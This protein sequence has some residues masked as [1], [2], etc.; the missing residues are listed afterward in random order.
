VSLAA[1]V[2][3]LDGAISA[4]GQIDLYA[5]AASDADLAPL[6]PMLAR[7]A[8]TGSFVLR[9]ARLSPSV[10]SATLT[11]TGRWGLA[12]AP[13][14]HIAAISARLDCVATGVGDVRFTLTLT[15]AEPGWT[16][17][18]T[19]AGLPPTMVARDQAVRPSP[20][21]LTGLRLDSAAFAAASGLGAG[22]TLA[23]SLPPA[24]FWAPWQNLVGPWPLQLAGQVVLPAA[25]DGAPVLDLLAAA[26]A[27]AIPLHAPLLNLAGLALTDV[28]FGITSAPGPDPAQP[29]ADAVT[30]LN[31]TGRLRAGGL[32]ARLACPVLATGRLWHFLAQFEDGPAVTGMDQLGKLF[33][34]PELP[35]PPDFLPIPGF[36]LA[37]VEFYLEPGRQ[38]PDF[39]VAYIGVAIE[40]ARHWSLPAP[41]LT[42]QRAGIS[43]LWGRTP[44]RGEPTGWLAATVY[45]TVAFGADESVRI[46]GQVQIPGWSARADLRTGD[47][48]GISAAFREYFGDAGP[49]TP[50]DMNIV[51]LSIDADPLE[52]SYYASADI[53]FGE[54]PVTRIEQLPDGSVLVAQDDPPERGWQIGLVIT[55]ITLR[56]LALHVRVV[57]GELAGGISGIFLFGD[58][59][60]DPQPAFSLSAEY[61]GPQETHPE[62]WTF[63][64]ELAI[65]A[66]IGLH[67]LARR[68]LGQPEVPD[69][70]PDLR[71]DR[72]YFTF[73][74]GEPA[75]YAFGGT[76][77]LRWDPV[78]FGRTLK[79]SAA[80][81]LD[82]AKPAG[83]Q[84]ASGS[85]EGLFSVN[86]LELTARLAIGVPEPTYQFRVRFGELWFTGTTSWHGT[87][88][89]RHQVIS[90]RLGGVTVGEVLE[91]LVGLVAPTLGYSL[92]PPWDVLN[93]I[94]LSSFVLTLDPQE[95]TA[96]LVYA[97][98]ADLI[99]MR[100][101]TIGIRY[102]RGAD[103]GV[104]LIV[105]GS[106]LGQR[107][108]GDALAWDVISEPPPPVPGQGATY[109]RLRYL[110]LG[111]RVQLTTRPDTV[112]AAI[113][114][115]K[116]ELREVKPGQNPLTGQRV[117]WSPISQW[118]IGL[119]VGFLDTVD[120]GVVFSDPWLYGLSVALH[121]EQAG[122]LAGLKFE[123]LYK[124]ISDTTG[125]FRIELT[126]PEAYRTFEFGEV[127]VTLGVAVIEIYTNGNFKIDLGFPHDRSFERSFAVQVFPFI[128]RGGIYLG[129]LDGTTSRR[130][131]VVTNGAFAPVIELGVG[132]TVGVG[133]EIHLGPLAGGIYVE[134]EVI[135]E[136]VLGWFHPA[137]G[138]RAAT[139]YW[140]QGVAAIHGKLYG[141]V[142]FGV[143][144]VLVTL[145]AYAAAMVTLEAFRPAI[146]A[147]EVTASVEAEVRIWFIQVSFSYEV[148]LDVSFQVGKEG[149]PPWILSG[150]LAGGGALTRGG[151]PAR[152]SL[153]P[154]R[155]P[156][157]LRSLLLADYLSRL[158]AGR[159]TLAGQ[160]IT[161]DRPD[162]QPDK[163][164]FPDSPRTARVYFLPS[165]TVG[166]VPLSWTADP[167]HNPS[168]R[169][170]FALQLLAPTG[171]SAAALT[172]AQ[173]TARS[174]ALSADAADAGDL[175]ALAADTLIQGLLLYAVYAIPAG[176][177]GPADSVTAGQLDWL[178]RM[179]DDP[180]ATAAGFT[181]E[182]LG[183]FFGTNLHL[184]VSGIPG[185]QQHP[186]DQ[187]GMAVAVPPFLSWASPQ[188]GPV[189]FAADNQVGPLYQWG[190]SAAAALFSPSG[191][192]PAGPPDDPLTAYRSFASHLF[193]DWCLLIAKS[194]VREAIAVL[195]DRELP[196]VTAQQSLADLARALPAATVSY[197]VRPGDTVATVADALGAT[198]DE[199]TFLNPDL[200]A[201]L[202]ATPVGGAIDVLIGVSPELLAADNPGA[203]VVPAG[204]A[205][206]DLT[207]PVTAADTLDILAAR[208]LT[209]A[210]A[211]L[212]VPG[213][214]A[215]ARLLAAGSTFDAP[216]ATW[217]AAPAGCTAL[218]AAAA[219]FTRYAGLPDAD[220]AD[221]VAAA[222]YAEALADLNATGLRTVPVDPRSLE[223]PPR[224]PLRIPAAYQDAAAAAAGYTTV[225]GDTLTRIGAAL[226]LEQNHATG[227]D[228]AAWAAFRD[229]VRVVAGGYSIP[230]FAGVVIGAA[231]TTAMLAR[232]TIVNWISDGTGWRADWPGLAAWLGGA[233]VLA[234][235][236]LITVPD[237]I[238]PAQADYTLAG[239][240]A[241]YSLTLPQLGRRLAGV[242]GLVADAVLTVRHL[243]ADTVQ[244]IAD[245]VIAGSIPRIAAQAS[246]FLLSGQDIPVPV[247]GAGGHVHASDSE[248]SPLFDQSRQQWDV[249]VDPGDPEGVAL[250]LTLSSD[251]PWITLFT[252]TVVQPDEDLAGLRA[253]LPAAAAPG[254]NR[255]IDAGR[256]L[257]AGAVAHTASTAVLDYRVTNA[258]VIA[259]VP[260]TGLAWPPYRAAAPIPVKGQ[261][262]VTYGLASHIALQC[263][264]GL[265]V[266]G[267]DVS[268][269]NLSIRPFPPGL[270][271][272]ARARTAIKYATYAGPPG[273][274]RAAA[275]TDCT[276]GCLIAITVRRIPDAPG[277]CQLVGAAAE[278]LP[279]LL[280]LIGYLNDPGTPPGTVA[281]MALPPSA[282]AADPA[283][284]A[285]VDGDAWLIKSNLATESEPPGASAAASGA[286]DPPPRPV[287]AGLDDPRGFAL[288]LWE[289]SS[290]G[291]AGYTFGVEGGLSGG[292]FDASDQATLQLLVIPGDQ[293]APAPAGRRLLPCDNVL[294][295]VDAPIADGAVLF[296]EAADSTDP[297]EFV[298]RPLLPAGSS[299]FE[300]TLTRPVVPPEG[301]GEQA[302][303]QQYSLVTASTAASPG[304][305]FL[306]PASGLPAA[307]QASAAD[308]E[309][310]WLRAR[311]RRAGEVRDRAPQPCWAYQVVLP[312]Y[313]FG[314]P[315]V[316]PDVPGLPPPADDPYR[317]LG[318]AAAA[319]RADF[320]I[321][322]GDVMGNRS[323]AAGDAAL[324]VPVGYTDP[325]N[326]P[327]TWPAISARYAVAGSPG[328]VTLSVTLAARAQS[329]M[330]AAGQRG[331]ALAGAAQRARE[332]CSASYY[333]YAQPGLTTTV[334]TT[335]QD[336]A[337]L[338]VQGA[339]ALPVLAA[340]GFLTADGATRYQAVR[341]APAALGD[342]V[343]DYGIGWAALAAVN[344]AAPLAGI[345]G[346][347]LPL[348]V[349]AYAVMASGDSAQSIAAIRRPG[350]PAPS[351]SQILS[352]DQ[353]KNDLPLRVGAVLG[354]PPRALILADPA[355]TLAV[356]AAKAAT[357][358]GWLAAD[359]AADAILAAGFV[360]TVDEVTVVTGQTPVSGGHGAVA[361][362]EQA[363]AAFADAGIRV[364]AL[365]LGELAAAADSLLIA[366][367]P[368]H[369]AHFVVDG[370]A[371]LAV[372]P[373]GVP[374][375][376]LIA[377]NL[378]TRGLYEA[379][380][381]IYLGE[382]G[383]GTPPVITPGD[384]DTLAAFA[385]RYG[386]PPAA[387]LAANAARPV[388][389]GTA[390]AIPGA[391]RLPD[392][393]AISVPYTLR[394]GDTLPGV[395]DGFDLTPAPTRAVALA[396]HNK[397]M[398]GTVT[399]GLTIDIEV[400]GVAVPVNTTGL[401]SFA[402]VLAAARSAAPAA[403]MADVA[404]AFGIPG[405]LAAGGLLACP[406][407][408]LTAA[409]RPDDIQPRYGV[410]AEAFALANAGVTGLLRPGVPLAA[411][412]PGLPPV[413]TAAYD[414]LNSVTGRF[415]AARVAAG[416]PASITVGGV[417]AANASTELFALAARGLLPPADVVLATSLSD[418]GPHPSGAFPLTV[419]LIVARP[420]GLVHDGFQGTSTEVARASIAAPVAAASDGGSMTL[421]GFEKAL[422]SALPRLR[423]ATAKT[424]G[425][426]ADLWAVDFGP[427]GIASVEI[428]RAVQFG[429]GR[430]ARAIA[431][432]PLYSELVSRAQV[433]IAPLADG[434]LDPAASV[435]HAYQGIDVEIWA[436]RFLTDLDRLLGPAAAAAIDAVVSLRHQFARLMSAKA[437]L[438]AAI[439][440]DLASVVKVNPAGGPA[441][442]RAVTDPN[443]TAGLAAAREVFGQALGVSLSSGWDTAAIV[444]YDTAVDSSWISHP[445]P[446]GGAA[447]YGEARALAGPRAG[448]L[449]EGA[450]REQDNPPW[451]LAAAKVSL[452]QA[453]AFLTLPLAVT[454]RGA[455][456]KIPLDLSYAVSDLEI[457][458]KPE[459]AAPGYT[460]S[461]WLTMTSALTGSSLPPALRV[462]PG[463]A[464]VPIPLK[465]FPA[466]P[467][468][469]SQ[470]ALDDPAVPP[471]LQTAARWVFRAAYSHEHA[472]QDHVEVTAD[473][474]L[475]A[476]RQ[477][478]DAPPQQDLFTALAQYI[479]VAADLNDLLAGLTDPS[480]HA[481]SATVAAAVT[482]FADLAL[483]VAGQWLVRLPTAM[484][485]E[486]DLGASGLG[487]GAVGQSYRFSAVI[488]YQLGPSRRIAS[489]T[490]TLLDSPAGPGGAWPQ[491]ECRGADGSWIP[492]TGQEPSV[493]SRTYLPS[494]GT[495]LSVTTWPVLALSWPGLNAGAIQNGR[496]RLQV[497]RNLD[498]LG[499]AGPATAEAFV[500]RT[501][502]VTAPD[503]AVP[504][505]SQTAPLLMTGATIR[506]AL[507]AAVDALFP[508]AGRRDDLRVSMGL[509]Y[510][511]AL[512]DGPDPLISELPVGLLPDHPLTSETITKVAAALQDWRDAVRPV[513]AGGMWLLSL[514]LYSSI[515]PGKRVLVSLDRLV[516]HLG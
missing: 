245:L 392:S 121:G 98:N 429:G 35:T 424:A 458:R 242:K 148:D 500:Y 487:D 425:H 120:I 229:G 368:A 259:R 266:P 53:I 224:V 109:L 278:Q 367:S 491:V 299:G 123:I 252:S 285:L 72:L 356:A 52:Q 281:R 135:F 207:I 289:G 512:T 341:P 4:A 264:T 438:R 62:G 270:L 381:L 348:T 230:A 272:R 105:T 419:E 192:V 307:P 494:G 150:D 333:Q 279:L 85:L 86:K 50:S 323:A 447:L 92:D 48:I 205:L 136:G 456:S 51:G 19:F 110:G 16:F 446:A 480:R 416:Q 257:P 202:T 158:G 409:A 99:F 111:Q 18:K 33:G 235:L 219:F 206:G 503:I 460:R 106:L 107:Y 401:A 20:S 311:T 296:A 160:A 430:L 41:F 246:R 113:D 443:L 459:P 301:D 445:P 82:L 308:P 23:G 276:F 204:L 326:G 319:P 6:R 432:A 220:T 29:A 455:Q 379:G 251:V 373:S 137:A 271:T 470:E 490:L 177:A 440:A 362:F 174:A 265:P 397:N 214:D 274:T 483:R 389:A 188:T 180:D 69:W 439:P 13:A 139:Y 89:A 324:R 444:Q 83:Q 161:A 122:G 372:N 516:Y 402:A 488:A 352:A 237:V 46:D 117:E 21:F 345:F 467:V 334:E 232:R 261:A 140:A 223:L 355:P 404:D 330:P 411:P 2:A 469:V 141:S 26:A 302:L 213:Q 316:A 58:G 399:Q 481:E 163:S 449:T 288:L 97:A 475:S 187:G 178:A 249:T 73:N 108:D 365:D 509:F 198:V 47:A 312:V 167:P 479:A 393:G 132:L 78:I 42:I 221:G 162:W 114:L 428:T 325:L 414:T 134:V 466:L 314:P 199:L 183:R 43:W 343:A 407:A 267:F 1:V 306:V 239:L 24:P 482:T 196:P 515:D 361:T 250:S 31:L 70:V 166:D 157:R 236:A 248:V 420:A 434:R 102:K 277:A 5:A 186:A 247:A 375:A 390:L 131:P 118:L 329:L 501:A 363:V 243:P 164:V 377:D 422:I 182:A 383:T 380:A 39:T 146:F 210:A 171:V 357:S 275:V 211:I 413:T 255:A 464:E 321:G 461:D 418:S 75:G 371:T 226:N 81:A 154:R 147:L 387:L 400:G 448:P 244:S 28:G 406:P 322:F 208:Y 8:I 328:N 505:I 492:L 262:P 168:P 143:I 405:R 369:T 65:G 304:C 441:D 66:S 79:I 395:A 388:V 38:P 77:S 332:H 427:R 317:G 56:S 128:G 339:A 133:K 268:R 3:A 284:I 437:L 80:A 342:I 485:D 22:L 508:P 88:A 179:L 153:A 14:E 90:L 423:L 298:T 184:A 337:V 415:N 54:P 32:V 37:S 346:A 421:G 453:A 15:I 91:Y 260:A 94:E 498:L 125:M 496:V 370:E 194:A 378:R 462:S 426:P 45:G 511:F 55:T 315:S 253:R 502:V 385:G 116:R 396:E 318:P 185:G 60:G 431:L 227:A 263:G 408:L 384:G 212:G 170:R 286:P 104:S 293:Q 486:G 450:A 124:K 386:C 354:Y 138:G 391:V 336:G 484:N 359:S 159:D 190:V 282:T 191:T 495:D 474:N 506:D 457:N 165:F 201:R 112:A 130:V 442:P 57:G 61:P 493:S 49:A 216:Q 382:F 151:A 34:L 504:A 292:A 155:R 149:R 17:G 127:S 350:W 472:A 36:R 12:G 320:A 436:T 217:T 476:P 9:A 435:D 238:T 366:G 172:A 101:D 510:G 44:I 234:P 152:G 514:T 115:L 468:L 231:E 215:D 347:G 40:S 451:R 398:P 95:S 478:R 74:T 471:T 209:T 59:G 176:P 84:A 295:S 340:G 254:L 313:R 374:A 290:V 156:E 76:I 173:G 353:N 144:Q 305:P 410:S 344:A 376:D 310:A 228:Q 283:G 25:Y 68:F 364:S 241:A 222:W 269:G 256:A 489:Y 169:Y 394:P 303:R 287:R 11:G 96:E 100:L 197:Q 351:A 258:E 240:A 338:A 189:N 175:A 513:S 473:F 142:D 331:D 507:A 280:G 218:R 463:P 7:F 181:A 126:I 454:D 145:E 291:G 71:V 294:L 297:A 309:P 93:R 203:A 360:F 195:G 10:T 233:P 119:D 327:T 499:S 225:P 358:A 63:A 67:D 417:V 87:G 412:D 193:G 103:S 349:P 64:G 30:V 200:Q 273:T 300:L 465:S 497:A 433:P 335:L 477:G 27:S 129:L 452:S 403:T